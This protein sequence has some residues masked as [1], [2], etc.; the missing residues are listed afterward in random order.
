MKKLIEEMIR[1][2]G[3]E[4]VEKILA[5]MKAETPAGLI[6]I[7]SVFVHWSESGRFEDEKELTL[8]EFETLAALAVED[9]VNRGG[10]YDKTKVTIKF[11]DGYEYECRID[12]NEKETGI[13]D[14]LTQRLNHWSIKSADEV[15]PHYK[16]Y[17]KFLD[18]IF[19]PIQN[20]SR[21]KNQPAPGNQAGGIWKEYHERQAKKTSR[22]QPATGRIVGPAIRKSRS[23]EQP[24]ESH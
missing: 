21:V 4:T 16:D 17:V 13:V 22:S 7:E 24:A 12:L 6:G 1:E 20:R 19:G 2:A 8:D 5:E 11:A 23:R 18:R 10:G 14:G 9:N 3:I 15:E